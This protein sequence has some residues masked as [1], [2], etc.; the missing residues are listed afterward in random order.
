MWV[1]VYTCDDYNIPRIFNVS[2]LYTLSWVPCFFTSLHFT[3]HFN[4]HYFQSEKLKN[5][6]KKEKN[7]KIKFYFRQ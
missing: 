5:M 3:S 6:Q 2:T 1:C 7:K 4:S